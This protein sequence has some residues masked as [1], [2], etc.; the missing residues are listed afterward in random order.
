MSLAQPHVEGVTHRE[1]LVRGLR[2]H[3]AEAGSG[4]PLV[5]QHGFPQHWWQW[6]GLIPALAREHR[7]IC[8]DLRGFG[9]S[10][11]PADD[12]YLKETLVDD[13]LALIEALELG[14]VRYIGH[15]WG[16]WM[17]FLLGL[18]DDHPVERMV[19]LSAPPPWP[20]PRIAPRDALR[21]WYQLPV[22]A[23]A[24][25]FAKHWVFERMLRAGRASGDWTHDEL[26]AYLAPL[27]QPERR[28]AGRLMYRAFLLREMAGIA[29]GRYAGQRLRTPVRQ[30][31]GEHDPIFDPRQTELLAAN[32]DDAETEVVPDA[33]HFLPEERPELV[34]E[35]AL[36][37]LG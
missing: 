27:R 7:V 3:V 14:R 36:A 18:R 21:F 22:A 4:P 5:L 34:L 17:G 24:P 23:P 30:L 9:W 32:A 6:R 25:A 10:E 20:P 13:L 12:D 15:D 2:I 29:R 31:F 16:A 28:R 1:V 8:P 33:G 11:T 35:R 26:E 19:L 37:F